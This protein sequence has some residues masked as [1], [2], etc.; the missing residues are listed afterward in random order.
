MNTE[1]YSRYID[2]FIDSHCTNGKGYMTWV[3]DTFI[4]ALALAKLTGGFSDD[5]LAGFTSAV[6]FVGMMIDQQKEANILD[7]VRWMCTDLDV[8]LNS[9]D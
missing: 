6:V 8:D 1:E 2:D 3:R 5:Y 4:D 7:V 9:Q